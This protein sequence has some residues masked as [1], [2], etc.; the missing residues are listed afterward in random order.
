M[1]TKAVTNIILQNLKTTKAKAKVKTMVKLSQNKIQAKVN[2]IKPG[3]GKQRS[4]KL[5]TL[6]GYTG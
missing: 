1:K 5:N 2:P 4:K 6:G 3:K